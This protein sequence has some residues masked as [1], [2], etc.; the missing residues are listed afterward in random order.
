MRGRATKTVKNG[1]TIMKTGILTMASVIIVLI[2]LLSYLPMGV[3][4][5]SSSE[6]LKTDPVYHTHVFEMEL[7]KDTMP[8]PYVLIWDASWF[9]GLNFG[10]LNWW[11]TCG[12]CIVYDTWPNHY[13]WMG[14]VDNNFFQVYV[15]PITAD[16]T[17]Q[18][19]IDSMQMAKQSEELISAI[20]T[21]QARETIDTDSKWKRFFKKIKRFRLFS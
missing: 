20:E 1:L 17:S 4:S 5:N 3:K 21:I 9:Q 14:N 10:Y 6:P 2:S 12:G 16:T 18:S 19:I 15:P 7:H 11:P 13:P 8:W